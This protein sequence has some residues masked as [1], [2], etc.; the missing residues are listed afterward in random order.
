[1]NQDQ[2]Q[3]IVDQ[4][5]LPLYQLTPLP[6]LYPIQNRPTHTP[7][8]QQQRHTLLK[9]IDFINKSKT[10]ENDHNPHEYSINDI[11]LYFEDELN[12]YL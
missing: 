9:I 11:N 10:N 12:K 1:M 7:H 8:T 4:L 2:V 6:Q 5:Q 3:R